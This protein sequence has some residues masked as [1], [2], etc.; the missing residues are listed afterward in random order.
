MNFAYNNLSLKNVYGYACNDGIKKVV[1]VVAT[2]DSTSGMAPYTFDIYKENGNYIT[3][4]T[5]GIFFNIGA[6]DSTLLITITDNCGATISNQRVKIT[7]LESG[8][9][10][11]F[12]DN[13]NVCLGNEIRLHGAS[14]VGAHMGY[15]WTGPDE[16]SSQSKDPIIDN[17]TINHEGN[18]ILSISGLECLIIDS[19]YI[20]VI[21]PDTGYIQDFTCRGIRYTNFGFDIEP[22]D[23]PDST[24]I[25][26]RSGLESTLY[27]CDSTA[28]LFLT[29]RDYASFSIDSVGETCADE[30]YLLLPCNFYNEQKFFYNVHFNEIALQQGFQNVDSGKITHDNYLEIAIPHGINKQDY[31]VPHNHYTASIFVNNGKC[32]SRVYDFPVQISYPNWIIEQKWNDVLT[33]LNDRYNGG[34]FFSNYEWYKNGE[35]L[36]G[37]NGSYIY[38]LPTLDFDAE[39]RARVTRVSD[40]EAVFTCPLRPVY[41][42]GMKV[43]PQLASLN[44]PIFIE[45]QQSGTVFIWNILGQKVDQYPVLEN[46]INKISINKTGFF[47]LE[48]L[49]NNNL[50]E[51]FKVIIK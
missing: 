48:I 16:F 27:R 35:K 37:E 33:L 24:Y 21:L 49:T 4:N 8:T 11:A 50:R 2:V 29:V 44:E 19:I 40:G 43:Y 22:L 20:T 5:T 46:Q 34:Y 17:A 42:P 13:T 41:R 18:Y 6:P 36:E 47:I 25:F 31:A 3:S 30:P 15:K 9:K 28:R 23:V 51:T 38:I 45:T 1:K 32:N 10:V 14:V 7:N 39:Y 26:Y 12:A